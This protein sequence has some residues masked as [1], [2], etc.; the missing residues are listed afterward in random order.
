MVRHCCP[1]GFH[2]SLPPQESAF[3][4]FGVQSCFSSAFAVNILSNVGCVWTLACVNVLLFVHGGAVHGT[5]LL[6]CS[7]AFGFFFC[8]CFRCT[9]CWKRK[10]IIAPLENYQQYNTYKFSTYV[11]ILFV[12]HFSTRE[13]SEAL[14]TQRLV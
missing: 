8:F 2:L 5:H 9:N 4:H 1:A 7:T 13:K 12:K 10:G 6:T 3:L 11:F 14:K